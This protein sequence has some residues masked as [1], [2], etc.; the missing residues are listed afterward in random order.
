[1]M[2]I[3]LCPGVKLPL[4]TFGELWN[5]AIRTVHSADLFY[6]KRVIVVGIPAAFSPI[7]SQLH[8]PGF[9]HN[10]PRLLASGFDMVACIASNDPWVLARW[11]K[12]VDPDGHIRFLSDGNLEFA[13]ACL[14]TTTGPEFFLGKRLRRFSLIASDG[15]VERIAVESG[16]EISCTSAAHLGL[17]RQA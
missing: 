11:Q 15:V 4:A 17:E 12:V 14:L 16:F 1:M 10:A 8:L 5:G 13:E 6:H 7:C 9:I 3:S 2:R